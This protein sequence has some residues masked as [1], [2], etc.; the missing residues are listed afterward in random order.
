MKI[1]LYIEGGGDSHLQD[2]LFRKGWREFFENAG[3]QGRMPATYRG[4]GRNQTFDDFKT[5]VKVRRADELPL[6]LVDSEEVVAAGENAWQHLERRDQ[7]H[8]PDGANQ[9]DVFL[10]VCC[11]ET[12][13][14]ADRAALRGFFGHEW[15]DNALPQWPVLENVSKQRVFHA[16]DQATHDCAKKKYSKGRL[17]FQLLEAIDPTLVEA[18]CPAARRLL[19]RLRSA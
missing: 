10:M 11:M 3:L 7:W 18:A 17:S 8:F 19:D 6:L 14:I 9:S 4:G 12:W 1:K 16:L 2:T 15:R 5:A 13:F